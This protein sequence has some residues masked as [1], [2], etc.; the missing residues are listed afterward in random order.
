VEKELRRSRDNQDNDGVMRS[1]K[2]SHW[3]TQ[4]KVYKLKDLT[5][6]IDIRKINRPLFLR[7][8]FKMCDC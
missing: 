7:S 2:I 3:A 8:V 6:A 1:S 5:R 4:E